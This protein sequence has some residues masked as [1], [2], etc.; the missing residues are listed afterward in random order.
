M[1]KDPNK[2][3]KGLTAS[4]VRKIA[5]YYDRQSDDEGADEI[6]NAKIVTNGVW[7]EIPE[8]LVPKV[9]RLTAGRKKSA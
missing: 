7:M 8:E 1:K 2:Y 5:D 9:R 3:P 6:A 4:K